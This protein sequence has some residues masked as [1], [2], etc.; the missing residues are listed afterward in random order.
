ML[1]LFQHP[2]SVSSRGVRLVLNEYDIETE[3][4]EIYEWERR[5]EFLRL[6]PGG[7]VPVL[8]AEK[9]VALSGAFVIF[10]YLDETRGSLQ[11][12]Q[13]FFPNDATF[14]AE[15]RHLMYWFLEKFDKEVTYPIVRERVYKQKM[16]KDLGGGSPD[17]SIL[18]LA[19]SNIKPHLDYLNWLV[20]ARDW[21]AGWSLSYADFSAAAALSVLDYLGE[22]NWMDYPAVCEWYMRMKSRPSFRSLLNDRI[23]G[24]P[25]SAR[26]MELDI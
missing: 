2:M 12:T 10:E 6:N 7:F 23:L 17:S 25:P 1:T 18:R 5:R 4:V 3:M 9:G 22:I 13:R 26:Y 11:R 24:F 8:L 21:V 20:N 19:R 15:V 14:R 16:P